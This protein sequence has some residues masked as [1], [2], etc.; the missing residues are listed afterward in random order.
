MLVHSLVSSRYSVQDP[1][2]GDGIT[3]IHIHSHIFSVNLLSIVNSFWKTFLD[4]ARLVSVFMAILN[5][6]KLTVENN[7][8]TTEK[9]ESRQ[10][11]RR[12]IPG[13]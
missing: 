1:S 4:T 13:D 12:Q 11:L 8:R 6:V 3:Y 9:Q 7:H 5:L 2:P 10:R